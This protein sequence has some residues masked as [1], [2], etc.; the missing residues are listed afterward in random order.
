MQSSVQTTIGQDRAK[1][2][3]SLVRLMAHEHRQVYLACKRLFDIVV[4]GCL[5]VALIP[6][7]CLIALLI[8]LDT[9]GPVIFRQERVGL[10]RRRQN[11]QVICEIGTFTMYKFRTMYQGSD[12]QVHRQFVQAL[13]LNDEEGMAALQAEETLVCKLVNDARVTRLGHLLRKSSLDELPQLVN[14]LKG[15]MSMVGPRPD[16]P[17]SVENYQPW[18]V[19]RLAVQP[20]LTC[21]WQVKGR[22]RVSFDDWIRM[23]IEYIRNQSFWLDLKILVLTIPAVLSGRGAE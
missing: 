16:V 6:L 20:G 11:G 2:T 23:D 14:V 21:L 3:A 19:E 13:I 22:S 5:L 1:P 4:A 9:P 15:Q 17:Y 7:M 8:I 18:H 10:K 12:S